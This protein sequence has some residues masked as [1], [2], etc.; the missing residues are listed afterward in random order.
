M[1]NGE[2]SWKVM[3]FSKL[4]RV[5]TLVFFF[6][7][8]MSL[9]C[10]YYGPFPWQRC[11]LLLFVLPIRT[12]LLSLVSRPFCFFLLMIA[13]RFQIAEKLELLLTERE[14][15]YATWEDHKTELDQAYDLHVFLRD[16]KQIDALT[17]TQE[18][19]W[20]VSFSCWGSYCYQWNNGHIRH[21]KNQAS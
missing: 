14:G 21:K 20:T 7:F 5:R 3:E 16:A 12:F 10:H 19:K 1:K 13:F 11:V 2:K 4:K 9:F 15:L 6:S 17:S 18:V 8:N